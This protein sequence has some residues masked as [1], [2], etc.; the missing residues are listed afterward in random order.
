MSEPTHTEVFLRL[1]NLVS[2]VTWDT[3]ARGFE[4]KSRR[5]QLWT[6]C[7]AQPALYMIEHD[8]EVARGTRLPYREIWKAELVVYQD[9]AKDPAVV[10]S[11]ENNLILDAIR[12][13]LAPSDPEG[14][15]TLGGLV[16][17]VK[18]DGVVFRDGG[19]LDGQ[20]VMVIPVRVMIP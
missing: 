10:G 3:P 13:V 17:S 16:H 15:V 2:V 20:G 12:A 14:E 8:D 6:D 4:Y 18:I 11:A 1:W 7:S 9:T 5:L 19:D